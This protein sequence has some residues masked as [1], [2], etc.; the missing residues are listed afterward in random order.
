MG[1]QVCEPQAGVMDSPKC[2]IYGKYLKHLT[3]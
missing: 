3:I 2:Q 1:A